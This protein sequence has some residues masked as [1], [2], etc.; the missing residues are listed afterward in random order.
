MIFPNAVCWVPLRQLWEVIQCAFRIHERGRN[1]PLLHRLRERSEFKG[2]TEQNS[3]SSWGK[4]NLTLPERDQFSRLG[5]AS[6]RKEASE[7]WL[8][9]LD[10]LPAPV[11]TGSPW[12][13][14]CAGEQ[15]LGS[16]DLA[17]PACSEASG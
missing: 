11:P 1:L 14:R 15:G 2:D 6:L 12:G 8:G 3:N 5:F 10:P 16:T 9:E 17:C 4:T 13:R 7:A